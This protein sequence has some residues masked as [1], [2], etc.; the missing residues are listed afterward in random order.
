MFSNPIFI[1]AVIGLIFVGAEFFVPGVVIVFFGLGAL[2]TSILSGLIPGLK[3]SMALQIILWL[4]SSSLS[5]AFLRKYLSKVFRG[6]MVTV[7]GSA[8]S[9]KIAEVTESISPENP[10]RVHFQGTTWKATS[11]TESF[12]PGE[13]VEILKED[14]LS[15]IVTKSIMD[16]ND[17]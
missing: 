11:F 17:G 3:H 12:Q 14:G 1:W 13:K 8:P 5:L 10:G 16:G 6:K 7:D 2:L 15:L 9:G 4:A